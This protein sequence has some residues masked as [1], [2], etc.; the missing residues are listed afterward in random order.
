[1][2]RV[3]V[4]ILLAVVSIEAQTIR[5][6]EP[7]DEDRRAVLKGSGNYRMRGSVDLGPVEPSRKIGPVVVLLKRSP[8]QQA[9]IGSLLEAQ[10]DPGLPTFHKWLTPE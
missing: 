2:K 9:E 7:I 10:R 5:L 1:M 4:P 8:E 3:L 6:T